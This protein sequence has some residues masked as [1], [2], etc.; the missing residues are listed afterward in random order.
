MVFWTAFL[1]AQATTAETL[2]DI[3]YG[4]VRAAPVKSGEL[5]GPSGRAICSKRRRLEEPARNTSCGGAPRPKVAIC[6]AGNARTFANPAVHETLKRNLA[7]AFGGDA[8]F[9][10][11]LKAQDRGW[12]AR[13]GRR[14]APRART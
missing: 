5:L 11:R 7:E 12:T 10:R 4:K 6:V 3:V 9:F 8:S 2:G 13:R 1:L 14:A